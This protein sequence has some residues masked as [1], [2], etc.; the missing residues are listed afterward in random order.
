MHHSQWYHIRHTTFYVTNLRSQKAQV[1]DPT[2]CK[3]NSEKYDVVPPLLTKSKRNRNRGRGK[4][5]IYSTNWLVRDLFQGLLLW[6]TTNYDRWYTCAVYTSYEVNTPDS[7]GCAVKEE[8]STVCLKTDKT[9]MVSQMKKKKVA[10]VQRRYPSWLVGLII[11]IQHG[12]Y[13]QATIATCHQV[14][15]VQCE[16]G[17]PGNS[18]WGIHSYTQHQV[19]LFN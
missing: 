13:R 6:M 19:D 9:S 12:T 17:P 3:K 15:L 11:K 10:V 18:Y 7:H 1:F 2:K 16:G 8:I 14:D 4:G 5:Y